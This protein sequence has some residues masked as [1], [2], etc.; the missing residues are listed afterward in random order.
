MEVAL[1]RAE[2]LYMMDALPGSTTKFISKYYG[3]AGNATDSSGWDYDCHQR[4]YKTWGYF[5]ESDS[6]NFM[7]YAPRWDTLGMDCNAS[8]AAWDSLAAAAPDKPIMGHICPTITAVT[9]ALSKGAVG[10]MASGVKT[11]IPSTVS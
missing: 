1:D 2:L 11:I 3:V 5:Y 10:I 9:T 7:T 6:S 8:Q 4:G